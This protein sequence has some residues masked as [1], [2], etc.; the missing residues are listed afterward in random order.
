M[1]Y[2]YFPKNKKNSDTE[3]AFAAL[4]DASQP[5]SGVLAISSRTLGK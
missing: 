3:G 2:M 1:F 5:L 4:W